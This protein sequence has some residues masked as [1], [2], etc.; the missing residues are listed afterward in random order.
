MENLTAMSSP[1]TTNLAERSERIYEERLRVLL[2][3]VLKG[4]YVAI[5]PDSGDHFIGRT[6]SEAGNVAH[7]TYPERRCFILRIGY[8]AAVEIATWLK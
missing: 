7:Q 2:E 6:M 3:P 5:E 8:P 4:E 1:E